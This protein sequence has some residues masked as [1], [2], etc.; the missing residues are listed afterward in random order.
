M[1]YLKSKSC[2]KAVLAWCI[3]LLLTFKSCAAINGNESQDC[4]H[5]SAL[6]AGTDKCEYVRENC[7]SE[8]LIPFLEL[9]YCHVSHWGWGASAIGLM[10]SISLL[11]VLFRVIGRVADEFFSLIL[12]QISQDMG[13]PPRLGGVTLL[14]LGNGA[15]DLSSSVAAVRSGNY[16]LALG[17]L[18][19]SIMF[20]GCVVAGR[21]ITINDGVRSRGAQIRDV[22]A[23][24]VAV[25]VVAALVASGKMTYASVAVLLILYSFYVVIVA[26][27]DFTNRAGVQ[28]SKLTVRA[29]T[30]AGEVW[31]N[32]SERTAL[33]TPLILRRPVSVE[34]TT[35]DR[36]A[37][38]LDALDTDI[39]TGTVGTLAWQTSGTDAHTKRPRTNAVA[40]ANASHATAADTGGDEE[41]SSEVEMT[42]TSRSASPIRSS[43]T[44]PPI[45]LSEGQKP[46][47]P[48][49]GA[50]DRKSPGSLPEAR[51]RTNARRAV[52]SFLPFMR[53]IHDST[54]EYDDLVHMTAVEYRRRAWA[55][56]AS[57]QSYHDRVSRRRLTPIE[58]SDREGTDGTDYEGEGGDGQ[59]EGILE[60]GVEPLVSAELGGYT[61]PDVGTLGPEAALTLPNHG[62]G[63][64][65]ELSIDRVA[66]ATS[67]G[68]QVDVKF[69]SKVR[70]VLDAASLPCVMAVKAT[71]PVVE[72]SSYSRH[73]LAVSLLLSPLFVCFYLQEISM[74]RIA[75]AIGVG[76]LLSG[77]GWLGTE[78]LVEE[79]DVD[80]NTQGAPTW[81]CG[82]PFPIGAALVAV[83]GFGVTAMWI[84]VFA[85]EIVGILH[86]LGVLA[87]ID[88]AVLGVTVL[89][90]G[91]SLT[92]LVA[93]MSMAGKSTKGTSMAMT[94]CFAGPLFNMLIGL[95]AGFWALL[96]DTK[97]TWTAVGFNGVIAVGC[98]FSIINCIVIVIVALRNRQ[99]LPGEFGWVLLGWYG[100]YMMVVL[101][102]VIVGGR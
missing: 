64:E 87:S 38:A 9:Y 63:K 71:V 42:E 102:M 55:E 37:A 100:V 96:A 74:M 11:I 20:V 58:S 28:W 32:I 27:A 19:G 88:P 47:I 92:D 12:S 95:G 68:G 4:D 66:E 79:D 86:F 90:W 98:A 54:Q 3:L 93:N 22:L 35:A 13:L 67:R 16:P 70:R 17:A 39:S 53:G 69:A 44:L 60:E 40:Y 89:A 15:P 45:H 6:P 84:D 18:S 76:L 26:V 82:S 73:W 5:V 56:M 24:L 31:S 83:Y 57:S 48:K 29:A 36:D 97:Q 99:R 30:L 21:I 52:S 50:G 14:A 75:F 81:A 62:N 43:R 91:N 59:D 23:Q 10:L 78:H 77:V 80:N 1:H 51:S 61:P 2:L 101:I 46:T 41:G 8:G 25:L 65:E 33:L 7:S 72:A 34:E 94:A 85:S 49:D